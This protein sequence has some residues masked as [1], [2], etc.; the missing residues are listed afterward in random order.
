MKNRIFLLLSI[1]ACLIML[2]HNGCCKDENPTLAGCQKTQNEYYYKTLSGAKSY[3]WAKTG[4]YWIYKNT[5]TGELDTQTVTNYAIIPDTSSNITG[6]KKT[7][8]QVFVVYER[9]F[10]NIYSSFNKWIYYHK[11]NAYNARYMQ[12]LNVERVIL[13]RTVNSEGSVQP[14]FYPLEIDLIG[15]GNGSSFTTFKQLIPTYTLQG[16]TYQNVAVFEVD[17]DPAWEDKWI[18]YTDSRYYCIF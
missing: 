10:V 14:F 13:D 18:G 7:A 11:T 17:I 12:D 16:K 5:K 15:A 3:L 4:S 6:K 8:K 9:L 1:G 2:L